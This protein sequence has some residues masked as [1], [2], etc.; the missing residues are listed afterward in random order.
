MAEWIRPGSMPDGAA[1]PACSLWQENFHGSST[2][3]M[4]KSSKSNNAL[5]CDIHFHSKIKFNSLDFGLFYFY[6][7]FYS[8]QTQFQIQ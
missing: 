7:Y 4:Q 1:V 6:C 2:V 5:V 8:R 3:S